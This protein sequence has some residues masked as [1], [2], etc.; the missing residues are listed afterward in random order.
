[1]PEV[2]NDNLYIA[3]ARSRADGIDVEAEGQ[4]GAG[5]SWRAGYTLSRVE[6]LLQGAWIPR[7][8]D[9]RHAVTADATWRLGRR[10]SLSVAWPWHSGWPLAEP[11]FRRAVVDGRRVIPSYDYLRLGESRLPAYGR[12]DLRLRHDRRLAGGTLGLS[13]DLVNVLNRRNV[14]GISYD[15][16]LNKDGTVSVHRNPLT[17]APLAPIIAVSWAH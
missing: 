2:D 15:G 11:D 4:V 10:W 13:L 7:T 5:L 17:M 8:Y 9:Q 1:V 14:R 12:L 6:D 3:P 16:L